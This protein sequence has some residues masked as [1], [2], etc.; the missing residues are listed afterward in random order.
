MQ[1]ETNLEENIKLLIHEGINYLSNQIEVIDINNEKLKNMK[2]WEYLYNYPSLT[3]VETI[4]K[5]FDNNKIKTYV[6]NIINTFDNIKSFFYEKYEVAVRPDL[7]TNEEIKIVFNEYLNM[8]DNNTEELSVLHSLKDTSILY[9]MFTN[10]CEEGEVFK[11]KAKDKEISE[12]SANRCILLMNH[13]E[14][15][16]NDFTIDLDHNISEIEEITKEEENE[17]YE[18]NEE[19]DEI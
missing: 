18:D 10:W 4:D 6:Q 5:M 1:K 11:T 9:E 7:V 3:T 8:L 17:N 19:E 14:D 15:K 13:F 2:C 16:L 12:S